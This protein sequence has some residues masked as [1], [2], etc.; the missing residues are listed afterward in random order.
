MRREAL[1]NPRLDFL[2]PLPNAKLFRD[3]CNYASGLL[4][5]S[6]S[7]LMKIRQNREPVTE[8]DI[9]TDRILGLFGQT[10]NLLNFGS[11]IKNTYGFRNNENA[12]E[13]F[14]AAQEKSTNF[15]N[16]LV[17]TFGLD[18]DRF[19]LK[20][21]VSDGDPKMRRLLAYTNPRPNLTLE[22]GTSPR[23]RYEQ[24]REFWLSDI[25]LRNM[26]KSKEEE[27]LDKIGELKTKFNNSLYE[28]R[29][30]AGV[31]TPFF[32]TVNKEHG[33]TNVQMLENEAEIKSLPA[34]P[35]KRKYNKSQEMRRIKIDGKDVLVEVNFDTKSG[36]SKLI[37][38]IVDFHEDDKKEINLK[39]YVDPNGQPLLQDRQRFSMAI[40][41]NHKIT[42]KVIARTNAFFK[43]VIEKPINND[44]GQNPTVYK[45]FI[46]QYQGVP[47]EIVYYHEKGYLNSKN[48]VGTKIEKKVPIK[49]GGKELEAVFNTFSGSAHELYEI[50][51]A[52]SIIF[53]IFPYEIYKLP[54]QTPEEYVKE[55]ENSVMAR[56]FDVANS[57]RKSIH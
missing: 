24:L 26:A 19:G 14:I 50:R 9:L 17:H 46:A 10:R 54:G 29:A 33:I 28:G 40:L 7:Q 11:V 12:L 45:R 37:K 3:M 23:A 6:R 22:K 52:L 16:T 31:M 39:D 47:F 18:R 21:E 27:P 15:I 49:I 38:L 55:M 13:R 51:R 56:S 35:K 32:I 5:I 30:G 57:L 20:D 36:V 2:T 43:S 48:H 42:D 44:H 25:A 34:H 41:G 1:P 53:L 8:F 4:G